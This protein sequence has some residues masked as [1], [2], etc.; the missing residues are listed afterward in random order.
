MSS[1]YPEPARSRQRD[2]VARDINEERLTAEGAEYAY[3]WT[4]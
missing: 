2:A 3:G 4:G 1:F